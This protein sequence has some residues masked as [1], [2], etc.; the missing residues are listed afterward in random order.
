MTATVTQADIQRLEGMYL[1]K[2]PEM[3]VW[4][5]PVTVEQ[6]KDIILRT[7][8]FLT[9]INE[10]SGGNNK[11]WCDWARGELGFQHLVEDES[12]GHWARKEG[13]EAKLRAAI[14]FVETEYVHNTWAASC[15]VYG[16]YGWC[17]PDGTIW[18]E[19]NIGKW[20][21]ARE[22]FEEWQALA[23]AFPFLDLTV[24]LFSGESDADDVEAVVSFRVQDG[25]VA[26][27]DTP[28]I[29]TQ[30]PTPPRDKTALIKALVDFRSR[31]QGLDDQWIRDYG[32]A[33][34]PLVAQYEAEVVHELA[35]A[36]AKP[37]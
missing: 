6:A 18:Y 25:Q 5:K 26:V 2:W 36:A 31:E 21:N 19:D 3:A 20:P 11:R 35:Q 15:Y 32:A 13:V 33:I 1:P 4:G 9:N 24:T 12:E 8:S 22:V 30:R 29:P 27:L 17:H 14:G 10:F 23:K 34:R 16:P 7:D 28:T 37:K